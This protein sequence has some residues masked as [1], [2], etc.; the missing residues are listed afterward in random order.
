MSEHSPTRSFRR[1][2][3]SIVLM[4]SVVVGASA[5]TTA[6]VRADFVPPPPPE[7]CELGLPNSTG[8]ITFDATFDS[9]GSRSTS[10][11]T[12]GF[13]AGSNNSYITRTAEFVP[14]NMANIL[15]RY[16]SNGDLDQ[17][18]GASGQLRIDLKPSITPD[19]DYDNINE[20]PQKASVLFPDG[21]LILYIPT[22]RWRMNQPETDVSRNLVKITANGSLDNAFGTS[23]IKDILNVR[24]DSKD[25]YI[26]SM[27]PGVA[28]PSGSF[29]LQ[30]QL[31]SYPN[32]EWGIAKFNATGELDQSFGQAGFLTVPFPTNSMETGMNRTTFDVDADGNLYVGTATSLTEDARVFK[33][34]VNGV[35]VQSFGTDGVLTLNT[36]GDP[37]EFVSKIDFNDG[38][39]LAAIVSG[40]TGWNGVRTIKT[41]ARVSTN[42]VLDASF[43]V[44]GRATITPAALHSGM[45]LSSFS[46]LPDGGI[47]LV[48]PAAM[49]TQDPT[50]FAKL[51]P[52]GTSL[53]SWFSIK[54]GTCGNTNYQADPLVTASGIYLLTVNSNN[55]QGSDSQVAAHILRVLLNGMSAPP[56]PSTP[57]APSMPAAPVAPST[58]VA[59]V[60]PAA[61][62]TTT[63]PAPALAVVRALP[64][65]SKPIVADTAI[66]TGEKIS[67]TFS[68]FKPFEFVQLIVA[69]T[70]QVIG[71][72]TA[73]AQ[74]VVTIE[75]NL[76]SGLGAGSHTLAVFAP[77]SGIGFT[78]KITVTQ[79]SLPATG[80]NQTNL[81]MI[82]LL[83][84]GMGLILRRATRAPRTNETQSLNE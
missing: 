81:F 65:A 37:A 52:D 84:F 8:P 29:L 43:G 63:L 46:T 7:P 16:L 58:T 17:T 70:P 32:T 27:T 71:S 60:T 22:M 41:V 80:T 18:W 34:S 20:T 42:G 66:S 51:S 45:M 2:A 76:P 11:H 3:S 73:N 47:L 64:T 10:V 38:K 56:A 79:A 68:G 6:P 61:V 33:F 53:T 5:L 77:A 21:S 69:S 35:A 55:K 72:G 83:L 44:G 36:S 15:S 59:S 19:N 30:A 49:M 31:G 50:T 57:A 82:A 67:V 40:A 25:L 26:D 24:I 4:A 54:L 13:L 78:Q 75:G 39:L 9:D 28:G 1:R 48:S 14:G 62:T 12:N 23:G 74:G